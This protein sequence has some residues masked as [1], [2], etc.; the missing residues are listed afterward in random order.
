MD[1]SGAC[2]IINLYY[3]LLPD[4]TGIHHIAQD[5]IGRQTEMG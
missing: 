1:I 4:D 2:H 3:E 5:G